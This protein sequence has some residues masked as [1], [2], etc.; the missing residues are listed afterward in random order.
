VLVDSSLSIDRH[1]TKSRSTINKVCGA[2]R[3]PAKSRSD[4]RVESI[5]WLT[6][7]CGL[8]TLIKDHLAGASCNKTIEP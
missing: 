7:A 5:N 2:R 4:V 1:P 8:S 3:L 6:C